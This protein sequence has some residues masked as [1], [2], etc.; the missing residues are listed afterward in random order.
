[1]N[2]LAL[3]FASMALL[4]SGTAFSYCTGGGEE[5]YLTFNMGTQYVPRDAPV[6]SV[7]G[8]ANMSY[9]YRPDNPWNCGASDE[10]DVRFSD[11]FPVVNGIQL[12]SMESGISTAT[13]VKTNVPGVGLV[14]SSEPLKKYNVSSGSPPYV[15]YKT[16]LTGWVTQHTSATAKFTLVKISQAIPA[17]SSKIENPYSTISYWS[18]RRKHSIFLVGTVVRSECSI[19]GNAQAYIEV[20]MGTIGRNVFKGKDSYTQSN[21]VLI[22]LTNCTPGSYPA[23]QGWNYYQNANAWLRLDGAKGSTIVDAGRG[24]L[25]LTPES[26]AK[27][28]AVQVLRKDG[29]TPLPLGQAVA[30]SR[31]SSGNMNIELKARYIQTSDSSLGPEPGSANARAAFTVTYK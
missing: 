30:I 10:W 25:G 1:M 26:T 14:V 13:I 15:P 27:G 23:N 22:P 11:N 12:P 9:V 20:P 6:G 2:R 28:V 18:Y 31:L 21:D 29:V 17:G 8:T 19:E 16:R 7:I 5:V 4:H 3:G 24:L